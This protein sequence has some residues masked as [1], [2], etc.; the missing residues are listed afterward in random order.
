VIGSGTIG[1]SVETQSFGGGYRRNVVQTMNKRTAQA[2]A[3]LMLPV[4]FAHHGRGS[5][6]ISPSPSDPIFFRLDVALT[7]GRSRSHRRLVQ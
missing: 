5:R 7:S 1:M 6:I 4:L 3:M 2:M